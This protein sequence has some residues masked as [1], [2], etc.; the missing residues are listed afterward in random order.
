MKGGWFQKSV[1]KGLRIGLVEIGGQAESSGTLLGKK[2][3]WLFFE[4]FN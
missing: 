4:K 2:K 1:A 3:L